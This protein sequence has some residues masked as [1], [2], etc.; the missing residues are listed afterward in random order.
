MTVTLP[1]A[2]A[3]LGVRDVIVRR[4][5]N[6]VNRLVVQASG[7][8]RIRFHTHLSA[9]GYPFLV[10]MGGGDWWQLR[11]DGAGSWWPV[12]RFDNTPLGR[13]SF[14]T[15][16]AL[17]PGGYGLLNG[18][19]FKRAE[20]PWLWDFAQA[21]GVLTTEA[22]RL[23]REGAWTTG[24]GASTFRIPEVRG[25]FLRVLDENRGMDV[26]RVVGSLQN[27][28]L[29]SHN[30]YLPTGTGSSNRPAPAIPD[31]VWSV[32]SDVNFY[33]TSGTIATT[34]PNP[35][36]DSDTFIGNIG[37]FAGETRPRNI[38]LPARIK[39]I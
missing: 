18:N 36:F 3:A 14:E 17:N 26:G 12:G 16:M 9:N 35:A 13:P 33:P 39:L 4:M 27:H 37:I 10:L 1:A 31:T 28:A 34:Y 11:S 29:Q 25:E 32:S 22:A 20:W 24:D 19:F 21:S 38:A 7:G 30:H 6:S 2:N 8:D 15:T 23:T 5:D